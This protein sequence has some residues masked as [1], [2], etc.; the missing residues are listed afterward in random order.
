[1]VKT[2]L[3]KTGGQASAAVFGGA[4][5]LHRRR[6]RMDISKQLRDRES[7]K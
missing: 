5:G 4:S 6:H 2:K 3:G 1:M 7:V